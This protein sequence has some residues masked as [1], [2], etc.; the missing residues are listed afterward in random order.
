LK[1]ES[2]FYFFIFLFL[3]IV[4]SVLSDKIVS[5]ITQDSEIVIA[6]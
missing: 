6:G 4:V 3:C 2:L 1:S 5:T